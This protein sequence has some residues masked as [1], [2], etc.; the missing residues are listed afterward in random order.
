MA[1]HVIKNYLEHLPDFKI[2]G[3]ARSEDRKNNVHGLDVTDVNK[4]ENHLTK[5]KYDF[6]INCVG[7][8]NF[9][10]DKNIK[11]A[12][13][14]NSY[15]PHLLAHYGSNYNFKLIHISTDCVFSGN[16]GN[17]DESA[18]KD[19]IGAYSQTKSL[20][21]VIDSINLTFRTSIIGPEIKLDGIGL[22]HWFMNQNK[23][24]SGY[25]NVYWTGVTTLELAKAIK[26]AI[27][28]DLK[29]VYHLVN[30]TKISKLEILT[31]FNEV[32]KKNNIKIISDTNKKVDKSLINSRVDF[33]FSV[34]GYYQM[35]TDMKKWI[36]DNREL[37]S[38]YNVL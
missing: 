17:Y 15:F 2:S 34:P 12:I 1:G 7:V 36:I 33:N 29:G 28:C 16:L 23:V 8:L 31:I 22:F 9:N 25:K 14:V 24:I 32:F 30:N 35:F 11:N 6:V 26:E 4:L 27:N 20:G 10:V 3:I 21:E 37:Y 5:N 38:H 18:L 13:F 19:G